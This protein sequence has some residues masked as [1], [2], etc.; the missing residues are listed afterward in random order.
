[1]SGWRRISKASSEFSSTFFRAIRVKQLNEEEDLL[2]LTNNFTLSSEEVSE[3][4]KRRWDI[5]VFFEDTKELLGIDQYQLMTTTALLRY[6]TVCWVAFSFLEEVRY[7]LKQQNNKK[8]VQHATLGEA[9]Y[10]VQKI[11]DKLF[12]KWVYKHALSGTPVEELFTS[13]VA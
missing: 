13:L 8:E 6:W 4:Y 12:L 10:H 1:M 11:H 3:I 2:L 9:R 5:E 7:Q